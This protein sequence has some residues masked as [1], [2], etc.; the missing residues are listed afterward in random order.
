MPQH[1][2]SS[3]SRKFQS[4]WDWP[5]NRTLDRGVVCAQSGWWQPCPGLGHGGYEIAGELSANYNGLISNR[6]CD[7]VSGSF[8]L[9]TYVCEVE[10]ARPGEM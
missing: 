10:K 5:F 7:P 9:R 6:D 4:A 3:R 2:T 1:A 8:P